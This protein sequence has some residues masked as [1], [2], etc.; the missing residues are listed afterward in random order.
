MFRV[1][2][3]LVALA[4]IFVS[5][6]SLAQGANSARGR[7]CD[8]TGAP[9]PSATVRASSGQTATADSEGRF[10][11]D[12]AQGDRAQIVVTAPGFAPLR[13]EWHRG[14]TARTWRLSLPAA[15]ERITVTGQ[16]STRTVTRL[17]RKD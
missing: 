15:E 17:T 11:V 12:L 4:L 16:A 14:D 2:T 1:C 10:S 3:A 5:V 7:V 9:V 6:E 8:S 13:F